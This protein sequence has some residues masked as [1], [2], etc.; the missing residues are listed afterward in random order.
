MKDYPYRSQSEKETK[1]IMIPVKLFDAGGTIRWWLAEY[2]PE[3]KVAFG[4]VTG[5]FEDEWGT[6]SLE[7]LEE[8]EMF[9][10]IEGIGD[11]GSI[12]RV[13]VD[14]Y[15]EATKFPDLPFHTGSSH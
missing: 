2:D 8:L 14:E 13:E 15:F 10:K 12:P 4:Y 6:V 11:I 7:E 9:V 5:F 3:S 1:D